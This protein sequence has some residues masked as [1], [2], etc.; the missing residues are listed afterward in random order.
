MIVLEIIA[1]IIGTYCL[2]RTLTAEDTEEAFDHFFYVILMY[3]IIF[4]AQPVV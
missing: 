2:I 1:G 3:S 4:L